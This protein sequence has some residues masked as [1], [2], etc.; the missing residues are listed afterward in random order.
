MCGELGPWVSLFVAV[1]VIVAIA[2]MASMTRPDDDTEDDG[3]ADW[4]ERVDTTFCPLH[5]KDRTDCEDMHE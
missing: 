4:V 5:R 2:C 3:D 1:L